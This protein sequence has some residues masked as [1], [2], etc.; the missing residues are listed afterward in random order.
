MSV[1][2]QVKQILY[3]AET[4]S[5]T[6]IILQKLYIIIIILHLL[7]RVPLIQEAVMKLRE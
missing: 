4:G 7:L 3:L 6:L 5:R 1:I 2:V